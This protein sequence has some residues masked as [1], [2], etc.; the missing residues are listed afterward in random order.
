MK[1]KVLRSFK[2]KTTERF[3][4][5]GNKYYVG[6]KPTKARIEELLKLGFIEEVQESK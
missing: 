6:K 2:D 4:M 3:Y 1:Y 5:K